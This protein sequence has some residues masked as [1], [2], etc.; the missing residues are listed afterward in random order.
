MSM[1]KEQE[2][3]PLMTPMIA[4]VQA[5]VTVQAAV[6]VRAA[7]LLVVAME[8]VV[9]EV[10]DPLPNS[11]KRQSTMLKFCLTNKNNLSLQPHN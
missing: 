7:V 5:V 6:T 8:G 11:K 2:V 10:V 9:Q 4:I 3:I 1:Q